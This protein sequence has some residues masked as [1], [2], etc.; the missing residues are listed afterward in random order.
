[1]EGTTQK[2]GLWNSRRTPEAS[3]GWDGMAILWLPLTNDL[4]TLSVCAKM[5]QPD[6]NY[7]HFKAEKLGA[8]RGDLTCSVTQQTEADSRSGPSLSRNQLMI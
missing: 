7:F 5:V 1:V 6:G 2:C 8:Q 4:N 3:W